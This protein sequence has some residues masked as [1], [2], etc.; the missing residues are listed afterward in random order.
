MNNLVA[1]V[2][3]RLR[4]AASGSG[5]PF[6]EVLQY[7]CMERFL[8]RLSVSPHSSRFLLKGALMLA[9]WQGPGV[10]A[11]RDIDLQGRLP[12]D[13]EQILGAVR[14]ICAQE[15]VSDGVVFDTDTA[16]VATILHDGVYQGVRAKLWAL[17][18]RMRV[19]MQIDVGFGDPVVGRPSPRLYP[20]LLD[21]PA[22]SLL[23][24]TAESTI[25]EKFE[26]MVKLGL[27]NGRLKDYYDIWLLSQ[28]LDFDGETL[29]DAIRQTF[30]YRGTPLVA[31]AEGLSQVFADQQ[32]AARAWAAFLARNRLVDAPPN[33]HDVVAADAS[34]LRPPT[35]ALVDGST[36]S[37]RWQAPGPWR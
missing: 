23:G 36:W 9:L 26:A 35:K 8:Y 19:R 25:A 33:L 20:T 5:R 37:R 31:D 6:Q 17:L 14:A 10:R 30:A 24:Y 18:G 3:Q 7:Y 22:P 11:T 28:H 12:D 21:F 1:S 34:F 13:P 4:N 32:Q 15:V 2:Q 16:Q 29:A 27:V